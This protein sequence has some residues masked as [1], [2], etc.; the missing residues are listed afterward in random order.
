MGVVILATGT[1]TSRSVKSSIAHAAI[2]ARECI[3]SAGIAVGDIDLLINVGVF[4]DA[5][6]VEPSMAALIQKEIGL[7]P[8]Y[9][10]YPTAKPAFSFDVMN[11]AC[12]ALNAVQIASAFLT[13]GRADHVLVVSSDAHPSNEPPADFPYVAAGGAILLGRTDDARGFSRV[14]TSDGPGDFAGTTAFLD[15]G[16]MGANGRAALTVERHPEYASRLLDFATESARAFAAA[17]QIDL[18]TT[19]L[20]TTQATPRFGVE[21]A[22]RLG[23]REEQAAPPQGS[24]DTHTSALALGYHASVASGLTT[25]FENVLFVAAGAGLTAACALYRS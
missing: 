6:M 3:A 23:M 2:A 20:V 13:A 19:L 24:G 10:K 8:D 4:R 9:V 15:H 12:G 16:T 22:T 11:G 7:N 1:S 17:E 14:Q 25:K 5:N 21:L 18:A